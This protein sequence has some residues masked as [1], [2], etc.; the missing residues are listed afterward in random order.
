MR[1]DTRD[2]LLLPVLLPVGILAAVAALLW[3][4]SRILLSVTHNA[5]TGTAIAVAF[6]I[7]VIAAVAASR[8]QVRFST[9]AS[10]AGAVAGVA[11]LA[12]GIALIAFAPKEAGGGGG[13]VTTVTLVAK[14]IKFE[15][16]DLSV[17]AGKPFAIA[18]DNEDAGTEH[19]VQIFA[20]KDFSGTPLFN[21][22]LIT[23]I[24][25]TTYHVAALDAGT[26]YFHCVVHPT[27]MTGTIEAQ[28]GGGGG[29]G[30]GGITV[31]AQGLQFD[32]SEIDLVADQPS[33]ITFHNND[34]GTQH[35]IAIYE[36]SS[37]AKNLFRGEL[38]TGVAT[39]TYHVPALAAG[40]YYFHCDVHPTMSGSVVVA[41]AAGG[42][43]SSP[44]PSAS[45]G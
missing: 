5:A 21:G 13:P 7:V 6:S 43:S 38:V 23:G 27:T 15:Q 12:G 29:P 34:A 11:M 37:L 26:Y 41:P 20:A 25:K 30:G 31:T 4:F 8:Q 19:D 1:R 22:D 45:G 17:P 2:R 33:T 35:N 3:G 36:D 24:A 28:P 10:M 14:N 9:V 16:T 40:T 18:F 44:S 42:G 32:T 39:A